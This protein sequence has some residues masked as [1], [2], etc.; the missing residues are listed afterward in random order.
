MIKFSNISVSFIILHHEHKFLIF[1]IYKE[2]VKIMK[3]F[4]SLVIVFLLMFC[5]VSCKKEK[6]D[7]WKID[8]S[9]KTEKVELI[10]ISKDFYNPEVD[11][12]EFKKRF[13][14]FQGTVPDDS[15]ALRRMDAV[16]IDI[17]KTAVSKINKEN[18]SKDLSALFAHLQYYFPKFKYPKVYLYSSALDG[19]MDPV[20]YRADYNMLFIDISAFMGEGN[21]YYRGLDLYLQNSMNPPNILPKVAEVLARDYVPYHPENR[22]FI[23]KM[24]YFG[25]IKL[26]QDVLLPDTAAYLKMNYT[27]EQEQ[28]AETYES[29]IWDFFVENDLLF[30]DDSRLDE[31]FLNIGPFS[32]FYTEIDQESSPQ[33]GIWT[34]WQICKS[35]WAHHPETKLQ[36]FLNMDATTIFNQADY[37]PK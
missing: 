19:I 22:K 4:Q 6:T 31:Q 17:Y 21:S 10:D 34:G 24:I 29:N 20:F 3:F 18:L 16:E 8:V 32:K 5:M 15:F 7:L 12:E 9:D 2:D 30:S 1:A 28:W 13:S 25:K 36:D 14:F 37:R 23:D 35:Y 11:L 33:I 26:L 27:E